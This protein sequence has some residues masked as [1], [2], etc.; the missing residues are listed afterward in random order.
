M[1]EL[2]KLDFIVH[3]PHQR[4]F[5]ADA[6]Y[7]ESGQP[8][9]VVVFVHGFKGF[10]DWGHFNLLADYFAGQGFFFI[11]M[12]LSHNGTS[13]ADCSDVH[14]MEAFGNNNFCL[15]LDDIGTLLDDLYT[16]TGTLPAQE[17]DPSRIFLIGHS[18]GGG[19]VLAKAA[20]D[21]R[22][23]GVATWSGVSDFNMRWPPEVMAQW[24]QEGVQWVANA[25][26]GQQMPLYYQ[27]V[28]NYQA[29]LHRLHLPDLVQ[30][31]EQPLLIL[32]GEEDETLP[33]Q[34]ALDLKSRKPDAELHLLP[35]TD[36]SYGGRHP[37]AEPHLPAAAQK[38]ADLTIQFIRKHG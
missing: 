19:A 14:D 16:P 1:P 23:T 33:V 38:A 22:V 7:H 6:R 20:E 13:V 11:K 31:I 30:Q 27:L 15:E 12:N 8:K 36:H 18:R 28:E 24:K 2:K 10:K 26:T 5:T 4:P 34:M 25:R 21:S 9:P 17:L 3:P 29:N 32:H 37:Y 35:E